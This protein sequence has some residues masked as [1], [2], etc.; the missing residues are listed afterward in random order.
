MQGKDQ[1]D[2]R[3]NMQIESTKIKTITMIPS[4]ET[5]KTYLGKSSSEIASIVGA[6]SDDF[7]TDLQYKKLRPVSLL[8]LQEKDPAYFYFQESK[9]VMVYLERP[10]LSHS[11]MQSAFGAPDDENWLASPAGKVSNLFIYPQIGISFS[12]DGEQLDFIEIYEEMSRED[13]L[14]KIYVDPESRLR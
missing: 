7:A 14:K 12:S 5:Y 1:Q 6:T 3:Q 4:I 10:H 13:Y 9:L 2:T 8:H 11:E